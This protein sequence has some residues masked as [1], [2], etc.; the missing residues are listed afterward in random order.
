MKRDKF[1][2]GYMTNNVSIEYCA[3]NVAAHP[4]PSGVY[5]KLLE[6]AALAKVNYWGDHYATISSPVQREDGF[7]QGR[8]VTWTAINKDEPAVDTQKLEEVN[9]ADI[10]LTLPDNLGFNGRIFIYTFRERDHT[11][12]VETKNEFR[13]TLSA[14]RVE[15]IL[16][17]L[18]S[19]EIQGS[20]APLVE[21]TLI[22]EEDALNRILGLDRLKRLEIHLVRPNADDLDVAEI[23]AELDAQNAKSLEKTLVAAP[24]DQG[25]DPDEKTKKQAEVAEFNGYVLG[26]GNKEDGEL[27]QYS[28]KAHPRIFERLLD[29]SSSIFA[30]ALSVA[31]ES[32]VRRR[33]GED[34]I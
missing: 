11:M 31:K 8:L 27:V 20:D 22:P 13:K 4:H 15:K 7:Y 6:T 14:S 18:F 23:L 10:D 32:I 30:A 33:G 25:L 2:L 28:T 1:G 9:L 21:V 5:L 26:K 34:L 12:F 17:G 29:Q 3:V 16:T 19:S 24:G